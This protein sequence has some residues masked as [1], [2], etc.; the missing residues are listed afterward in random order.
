MGLFFTDWEGPWVTNDFAYDIAIEFL[1]SDNF[2]ER[3]SQYD[4]YLSYI[5]QKKGY[6]AGDTLKLLS[7]FILASGM[8]TSKLKEFSLQKVKFVPDAKDALAITTHKP[9]VISTAYNQFLE[10]STW[11][12]GIKDDFHGTKLEI[13]RY[14][15][16]DEDKLMALNAVEE[17]AALPEITAKPG[18][19]EDELDNNSLKSIEWLNEFFWEKMTKTSFKG[20]LNDV[21][22]VGGER[23]KNIVKRYMQ[24]HD[25]ES[26]IAIGDSISDHAMLKLVKKKGLS[27]SFNGNEFSIENSNM[28]I[29][30]DTAY[31]EVLVADIYLNEGFDGVENLTKGKFDKIRPEIKKKLKNSK[32]YFIEENDL[33]LIL[34]ESKEMRKKIRGMAGKLG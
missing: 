17:I 28:A 3:L 8:S 6:E 4:D 15:I 32:F 26:T 18:M 27:V 1:G 2:F 23:K 22:A 12:L 30:S 29:I 11:L 16:D 25:I 10:I 7:P 5:D 13:E 20:V 31:S 24:E 33:N 21:K 19:T 9:V 34:K 14:Q